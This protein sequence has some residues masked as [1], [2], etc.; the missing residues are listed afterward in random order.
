LRG[1]LAS[2]GRQLMTI[3]LGSFERSSSLK[4]NLALSR[5]ATNF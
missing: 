3:S 1:G 5:L 2:L 4:A